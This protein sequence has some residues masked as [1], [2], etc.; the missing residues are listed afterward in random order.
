M[1]RLFVT[2]LVVILAH[3]F[4]FAQSGMS[5]YHLQNSTIQGNHFN[6]S[7]IPEGKLFFGIPVLSGIAFD[8]NSRV[9]Y[10]D[11]IIKENG[12]KTWNTENFTSLLKNRNYVSI[13]AEISTFFLGVRAN[14]TT[15][16]SL[17]INDKMG[18]RL[19]GPKDVIELAL[20]GNSSFIGRELDLAKV[21]ADARYYREIGLG[22]WKDFP[23][24]KFTIGARLK[25]LIGFFNASSSNNFD[26]KMAIS[27]DNFNT[28]FYFSN[29]TFNTSGVDLFS[30]GSSSTISAHMIGNSNTGFGLDLGAN[31]RINKQ[32]S[33]AIAINDLGFIN[34]K[35]D[36][37]NYSVQDTTFD[38]R[39]INLRD[40]DNFQQTLEDSISNKFQSQETTNS[41][42]TS[43]NSRIYASMTFEI[44]DKS[45]VTGSIANHGVLGR[46]RMLYAVGYTR[47]F[48]KI[49]TVSG[50]L[51]KSP[52]HGVDLGI[53]YT[54]DLGA[55]QFYMASD[56]LI[57]LRDATN[58]SA[59]DLRFGINLIFGKKEKSDGKMEDGRK[60]GE[61]IYQKIPLQKPREVYEKT[62]FRE[63]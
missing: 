11:L 49:F 24:K 41:Y 16:Y 26:G 58:V 36:P 1:K 22:Y 33:A 2:F 61:N 55:F 39:G 50:N 19:F 14:E 15:A 46:L 13:E 60:G 30:D 56:K 12:T 38:Y 51:I 10:N 4:G 34:W 7:F 3:V 32:L 54:V 28:N 45:K 48:G 17:F 37:K 5:L 44:D 62:D 47:K 31:W 23:D 53:G 6:P 20:D 57:G 9:S 40:I 52:Q 43:L 29:A 35:V 25:Y 8:Y 18:A 27:E 21:A 42:K 63:I 59:L